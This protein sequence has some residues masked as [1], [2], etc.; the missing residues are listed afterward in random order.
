MGASSQIHEN[1]EIADPLA[2]TQMHIGNVGEESLM[3]SQACF[4][5]MRRSFHYFFS[6]MVAGLTTGELTI[7]AQGAVAFV[8]GWQA[9]D[10]EMSVGQALALVSVVKT[11]A[12]ALSEFVSL[13]LDIMEGYV[14]I[15]NVARVLNGPIDRTAAFPSGP[16]LL[17]TLD[18]AFH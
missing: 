16:Q 3:F 9:I 2:S 14:S 6:R 8:A 10:G 17:Q 18:P 11:L 4:I 15:L 7:F 1:R 12:S 5:Y 13:L